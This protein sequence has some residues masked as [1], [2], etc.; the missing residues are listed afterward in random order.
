MSAIRS[1]LYFMV[2]ANFMKPFVHHIVGHLVG[3]ELIKVLSIH[4]NADNIRVGVAD[5]V[6]FVISVELKFKIHGGIFSKPR[7]LLRAFD[8]LLVDLL[9]GEPIVIKELLFPFIGVIEHLLL[10]FFRGDDAT[11]ECGRFLNLFILRSRKAESQSVYIE[12]GYRLEGVL[13]LFLS[14]GVCR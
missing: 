1:H 14:A 11:D 12:A 6:G 7:H 5:G 2:E 3:F 13:S 8:D 4:V 9:I 10:K